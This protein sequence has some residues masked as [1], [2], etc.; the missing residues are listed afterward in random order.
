MNGKLCLDGI[1]AIAVR[2]ESAIDL[3]S[4][5]FRP[6]LMAFFARRLADHAEAEDLTQEVFLRLAFLPPDRMTH[7]DAY[8]FQM[9]APPAVR[10]AGS[11]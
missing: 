2:E 5:R 8:V 6:A 3:L 11:L 7:A 1:S 9:A 4:R 10:H